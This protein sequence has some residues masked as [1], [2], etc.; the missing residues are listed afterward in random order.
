MVQW[1]HLQPSAWEV[2]AK[3]SRSQGRPHVTASSKLTLATW[4]PTQ[5]R[6]TETD[7]KKERKRENCS[8]D[9]KAPLG[10][11]SFKAS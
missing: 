6:E 1:P 8:S 7:R 10:H 3:G 2:E 5:G 4:A 11:V 9:L